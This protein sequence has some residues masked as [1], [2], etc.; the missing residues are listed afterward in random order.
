M[1]DFF[2]VTVATCLIIYTINKVA[3]TCVKIAG[4]KSGATTAKQAPE[5]KNEEEKK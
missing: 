4:I 5:K 2:K 3:D 1:E